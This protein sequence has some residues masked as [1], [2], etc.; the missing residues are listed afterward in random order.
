MVKAR[1]NG[2]DCFLYYDERIPAEKAPPGHPYMYH[3]RHDEDD[4]TV[5]ITLERLVVVNFFGT[6]FMKEPIQIGVDGYVE[7]DDFKMGGDFVVFR[8]SGAVFQNTF[9]LSAKSTNLKSGEGRP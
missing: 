3:I 8:L 5:P 9:G 7:I 1:I 6:V 4:W 2:I